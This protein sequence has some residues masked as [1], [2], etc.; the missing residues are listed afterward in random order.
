MLSG[1]GWTS[2]AGRWEKLTSLQLFDIILLTKEILLELHMRPAYRQSPFRGVSL[3][4]GP[5]CA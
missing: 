5:E 1:N 4:P 3:R 2:R